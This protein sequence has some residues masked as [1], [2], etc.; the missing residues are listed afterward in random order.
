MFNHSG[1]ALLDPSKV[2]EK[3][4]LHSGMRVADLGCGRTGHFVMPAAKAVGDIGIVYALDIQKEIL[5]DLKS[6]AK[7]GGMSNIETVWADLENQKSVPIQSFTLDACWL[8][9]VMHQIKNQVAALFNAASLVKPGGFLAIVDWIKKLG[10][11]G[12]DAS[13]LVSRDFVKEN[14]LK[15]GFEL[16]ED[17]SINDYQFCLI[18]KKR[19]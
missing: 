16:I 7:S 12:P 8:V 4:G 15:Q 2:F 13:K 3:I 1:A 19:E 14:M 11:L 6:R 18:F 9:S 10:A 5:E 17:F